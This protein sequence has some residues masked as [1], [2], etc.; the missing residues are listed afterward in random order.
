MYNDM[1]VQQEAKV[2]SEMKDN[3]KVFF[4]FAKSRQKTHAKVGPFLDPET[5]EL[6]LDP[7][8]TAECLSSQYSSVFTKPRPEWSIPNMEDFFGVDNNSP[9]GSILADLELTE[10]DIEYACMELSASSA[11]GP[12]GIPAALLKICRKE[13]KTPLFIMWRA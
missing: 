4:S 1:T 2:I 9:T 6:N 5:G 8:Y 10:S 13:L 7:D 12:D 3:P 11:S